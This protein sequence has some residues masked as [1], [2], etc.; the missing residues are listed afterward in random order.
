MLSKSRLKYIQSLGH[1]KQRDSDR[2]FIAEGP[3]I[4]SD[5]LQNPRAK[6]VYVCG[7]SSWLAEYAGSFGAAEVFEVSDEE[8]QRMSQLKSAHLAIGVFEKFEEIAPIT[9]S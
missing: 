7:L 9:G 3:K 2:V 8:L 5:L 6:P 1:K 4:L